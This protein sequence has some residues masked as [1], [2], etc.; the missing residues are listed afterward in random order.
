MG[1]SI[2]MTPQEYLQQLDAL[3]AQGQHQTIL[4]LAARFGAE[5]HSRLNARDMESVVG[6]LEYCATE[7]EFAAADTAQEATPAAPIQQRG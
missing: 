2:A 5:V 6:V 3:L 4:D 7:V 1:D